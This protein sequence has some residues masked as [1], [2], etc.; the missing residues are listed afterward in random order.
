M[1]FLKKIMA[2]FDEPEELIF[3]TVMFIISFCFFA[4]S[5]SFNPDGRVFP[6]FTSSITLVCI[7]IHFIK[8]L[9]KA[10][11]RKADAEVWSKEEKLEAR[12]SVKKVLITIIF[13]AIYI[14]LS[15]LFGFLISSILIAVCYP[16][17]FGYKKPIGIIGLFLFNAIVVVVFQKT[18]GIPLTRGIL[19]DFSPLFF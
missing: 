3:L 17:V 9:R 8:Q 15:H 14:I 10:P 12:E 18:L 7:I 6:L 4:G 19:V 5:F 11:S 13:F 1:K 16:L 2:H